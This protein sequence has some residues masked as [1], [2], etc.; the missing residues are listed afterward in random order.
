VSSLGCVASFI[1]LHLNAERVV[2]LKL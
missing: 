1:N 2:I